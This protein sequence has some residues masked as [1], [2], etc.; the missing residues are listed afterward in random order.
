ML[1]QISP[2]LVLLASFGM[3]CLLKCVAGDSAMKVNPVNTRC[4]FYLGSA[5]CELVVLSPGVPCSTKEIWTS[6]LDR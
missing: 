1:A 5:L 4:V 2:V 6:C 3:K